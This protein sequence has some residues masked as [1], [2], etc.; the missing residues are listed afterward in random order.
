MNPLKI[1]DI[2]TRRA[3]PGSSTDLEIME[4]LY[5]KGGEATAEELALGTRIPTDEIAVVIRRLKHA[6]RITLQN[7]P[8][9]GIDLIHIT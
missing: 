1:K 5:K 3:D 7:D 4:Q 2:F 8:E 6:G 9:L